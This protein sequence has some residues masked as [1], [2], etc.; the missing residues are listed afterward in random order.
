MVMV[1]CTIIG[2][3]NQSPQEK[4]SFY[5]LP[6]II[7]H[8]GQQM[9]EIT[10]ERCRVWL[11]AISRE[12]LTDDKLE[13][14]FVEYLNIMFVSHVFFVLTSCNEQLMNLVLDANQ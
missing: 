9:L 3:N 14:V 1:R 8:Q 10:T 11:T 7:H 4:C 12:D 2:C 13:N 6:A 5:K